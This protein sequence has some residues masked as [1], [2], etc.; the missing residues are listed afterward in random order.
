[1]QERD[2]VR[3]E[4]ERDLEP[5]KK[6]FYDVTIKKIYRLGERNFL[7]GCDIM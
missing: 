2:W 4:G 1:M 3:D 6:S 5:K 7:L